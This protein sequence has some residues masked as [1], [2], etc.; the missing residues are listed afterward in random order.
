VITPFPLDPGAYTLQY[1]P[2]TEVKPG[3]YVLSL[4]EQTGQIEPRRING[5]LDMGVKPVFE[6]TTLSRK[7]IKITGNHPYLVMNDR[8]NEPERFKIAVQR[9]KH[10]EGI[11]PRGVNISAE[12][13]FADTQVIWRLGSFIEDNDRAVNNHNNDGN[14][15][16][17]EFIHGKLPFLSSYGP[18]IN[19]KSQNAGGN[20]EGQKSHKAFESFLDRLDNLTAM[21]KNMTVMKIPMATVSQGIWPVVLGANTPMTSEANMTLAPSRKKSER[22][23]VSVL[24]IMAECTAAE[25]SCQEK[26]QGNWLK[27]IYLEAGDSIA[28]LGDGFSMTP[29]EILEINYAGK[30]QVYDIEVEGSHNFIANGIIAHNTYIT[31]SLGVSDSS[32]DASLEVV[33]DGSGDSFL[34][35]DTNDGDTS[36][37][38]ISS[39]GNVGI[40]TT[41]PGAKLG[42]NSTTDGDPLIALGS[43]TISGMINSYATLY[44]NVDADNS[45]NGDLIIGGDRSGYTG[46]RDVAVFKDSGNV[47]IGTTSPSALLHLNGTAAIFGVGEAGSPTA[48]TL[49]G[50]AASGTDIAGASLTLDA[51]N[52]TGTGGS[53]ALVFRTAPAGSTG[54]TANTFSERMRVM[55][56]GNV[57]IGTSAAVGI[58]DARGDQFNKVPATNM[59]IVIRE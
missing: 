17:E 35:A 29:D 4:N 9:I 32:P 23:S 33:N 27:V 45:G 28:T 37:F 36:P 11:L 59:K 18:D 31:G 15:V 2:I 25:D 57:G 48:T 34:V 51:S 41:S 52:G 19:N 55:N 24:E 49:R 47:G 21:L 43:N 14:D 54:T 3:D 44:I 12:N 38:V 42:I 50:A 39:N 30:E 5:L 10:S 20:I 53:G 1:L 8:K 13:E 22:T 46:G 40:G 7:R 6:M 16:K 56:T 26:I 58:L